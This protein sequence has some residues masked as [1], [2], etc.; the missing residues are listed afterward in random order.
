MTRT[1]P[2]ALL[3]LAA[4]VSAPA[5]LTLYQLSDGHEQPAPAVLNLGMAL[6]GDAQE[7]T[8][9]ARN[10][11]VA[12]AT[13][14]KLF[15]AGSGFE[16][17]R[18]PTIPWIIAAGDYVDFGVRFA[19][20]QYG[21][22]SA[23]L[24]VNSTILLLVGR[25]SA[26]LSLTDG[27]TVL[28]S[29]APIDFGNTEGGTAKIR[30]FALRN[31]TTITLP[32]PIVTALGDAFHGPHGL[33]GVTELRPGSSASFTLTFAPLGSGPADG[34]LQVGERAYRL[35]GTG[36]NPPFPKPVL[37]LENGY[38][39]SGSLGRVLVRFGAAATFDATGT[40]K[41][42]FQPNTPGVVD[43]AVQ[44]TAGGRRV[45]VTAKQGQMA[46]SADA[47]FQTGTTAGVI[48][49][50]VTLGGW[51]DTFTVPVAAERV[52]LTAAKAQRSPD[53]IQIDL[54]SFD[55]TRSIS[56]LVFTFYLNTGRAHPNGSVTVDAGPDFTRYFESSRLGGSF[57]LRVTFPIT[58]DAGALSGVEMEATNNAGTTLT[59]RLLF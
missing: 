13:L 53:R 48:T 22:Y 58:G 25:T 27:S 8:L 43:D 1:L 28:G 30:T 45:A 55:N 23:S 40:L 32:V 38:P 47:E 15:V 18:Y 54:T 10:E 2:A 4:A 44:F 5:Q 9:R 33:T 49:F 19:P 51:T 6:T 17:V 12:K 37:L 42:D 59:P 21:S 50:T 16:L 57:A 11:G 31:D 39:A 29:I 36:T 14:E 26:A 24:T 56:R 41:L 35:L 46:A 34:W 20:Q 7:A 52:S 3:L